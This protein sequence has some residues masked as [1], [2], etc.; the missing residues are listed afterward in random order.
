ME[1]FEQF[2]ALALEAEGFVVSEAIKFPVRRQTRKLS[3]SE[4][5]THGYEVD[6][7]GA[8]ADR[9]VLAT[10]KSFFGSRGVS[11]ASVASDDGYRLLNDPLIRDGVIDA[12]AK[13]YGY[14]L[15]QVTLRLYVGKW[16]AQKT[17]DERQT[18][19]DWALTQIAGG[20]PIEVY[21]LD[22][23]ITLVEAEA[24]ST[25][26]RNNPVLTT[27]KVLAAAGLLRPP[28]DAAGR[29]ISALPPQQR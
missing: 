11:A 2:V 10:V 3:H 25:S 23:V 7:V 12:A 9:L 5:Q 17:R 24:R 18:T 1:S 6:L 20:G 16:A 15:G 8:R 27:W 26:Y 14:L 29:I 28:G 21:G 22:D 4:I 13:R 19:T